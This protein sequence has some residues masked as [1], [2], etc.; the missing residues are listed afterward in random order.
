RPVA[1]L[2]SFDDQVKVNGGVQVQVQVNVK[3]GVKVDVKVEVNGG[4]KVKVGVAPLRV[5]VGERRS[6]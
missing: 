5:G 2:C 4:V 3:V 1:R 6:R